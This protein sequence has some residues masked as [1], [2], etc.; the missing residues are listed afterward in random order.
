MNI[1]EIYISDKQRVAGIEDNW[2]YWVW[3][4][5]KPKSQA[6]VWIGYKYVCTEVISSI[7]NEL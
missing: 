1:W 6:A 2:L 3:G 5:Q 4:K 7:V